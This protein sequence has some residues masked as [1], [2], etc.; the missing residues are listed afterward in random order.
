[1]WKYKLIGIKKEIDNKIKLNINSLFIWEYIKLFDI[2]TVGKK[3]YIPFSIE[4]DI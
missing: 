2:Y 1:M 3:I 4:F